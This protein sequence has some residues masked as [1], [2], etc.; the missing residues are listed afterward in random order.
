MADKGHMDDVKAAIITH[1]AAADSSLT[2]ASVHVFGSWEKDIWDLEY[3]NMPIVTVRIG[4]SITH[5]T[6]YGRKIDN[7]TTG[8]YVSFFFTAHVFHTVPDSGDLSSNAM[9]LAEKIK[10]YF[11]K[12]DD[13][14]S[15]I[16]Y[17]MDI[18]LREA[19]IN[20]HNIARVIVE[21][22]VFCER[23]HT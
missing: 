14:A 9:A 5:E 21:G 18:T 19:K 1:I 12:A 7:A 13:S 23:P 6:A 20:I 3:D 17:Y 15:G 8:T 11:L 16:K 4:P 2:P 10:T 22:Y